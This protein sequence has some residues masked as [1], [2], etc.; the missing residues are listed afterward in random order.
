[1]HKSL[2][3]YLYLIQGLA[4]ALCATIPLTYGKMP[5]Y[6]TLSLF[7]SALLPFSFKFITGNFFIHVAPLVEK[8]S[9][10]TYGRRKFWVVVSMTVTAI[11]LYFISLTVNDE[12]KQV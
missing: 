10:L 4:I 11:M 5:D 8:Y 7:S 1:M 9:L 3:G 12:K 2:I 6:A